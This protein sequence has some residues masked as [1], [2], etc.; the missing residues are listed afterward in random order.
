MT[1]FDANINV[2][3]TSIGMPTE[4][5]MNAGAPAVLELGL[6]V[7]QQLPFSQG[8]GQPPVTAD[9]GMLRF[10]LDREVAIEFFEKGLEAAKTLPVKPNIDIATNLEGVE[11][12]A[13]QMADLTKKQ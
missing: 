3:G 4:E 5:Q 8:P 6:K 12:A 9:L 2:V 7:G 11:E 13:K 1:A 10:T